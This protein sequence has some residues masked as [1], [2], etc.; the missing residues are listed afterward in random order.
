M[1]N[2]LKK[3]ASKTPL[4]VQ[5]EL[6]R[7][8]F[9]RQI[10]KGS[11]ITDEPEFNMLEKWVDNGA[12]VLDIGANI[13]HYTL[14]LSALVGIR[15]RVIA[16]EPVPETFELLAANI[17]RLPINNVTLMNIAVSDKTK[18]LGINIPEF[19]SGLSNYY[20]ASLTNNSNG[21]SVLCFSIDS[22]N[23]CDPVKLVKIDAEGHEIFAL[24][25]MKDLLKRDHPILIVEGSSDEVATF[26]KDLGYSYDSIDGSPNR[27]YT[28]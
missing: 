21:L 17:A 9:A 10:K 25:G 3:I 18:I 22:L 4:W 2:I 20:Q 24:K 23:I 16:F 27:M 5:N 26:L 1:K 8:Y 11:F 12:Y 6:K 15:G 13:G 28:H 19:E 14:K 7:Y